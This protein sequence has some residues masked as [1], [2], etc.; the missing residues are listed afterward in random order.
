[1]LERKIAG[2]PEKTELIILPEMFSTG[3]SMNKESLAETMEGPTVEW[4]RKTAA[5]KGA[6]ITGKHHS[7]RRQRWKNVLL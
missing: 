1:M 3:F 7:E 4:M 2:F 6:I 5:E